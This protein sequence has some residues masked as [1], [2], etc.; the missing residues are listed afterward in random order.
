MQ[1]NVIKHLSKKINILLILTFVL[2]ISC[3]RTQKKTDARNSPISEFEEEIPNEKVV[4]VPGVGTEKYVVGQTRIKNILDELGDNDKFTQGIADLINGDAELINRY[5]F[6]NHGMTFIT[7]TPES[8]GQDI[9][10][11]IVDK[12]L[13]SEKSKGELN[14]GIAI[15]DG[16][17]KINVKLGPYDDQDQN[18]IS[19]ITHIY[20]YKK[21]ITIVVDDEM[22]EIKEYIIYK[23]QG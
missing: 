20:Y 23:P 15:G 9:E 7:I 17:E 16:V 5:F 12:I 3:N 2:S 11:A 8:K 1:K 14:N 4:I 10:N 6:T 18:F 13:F 22:K 21:G 19:K